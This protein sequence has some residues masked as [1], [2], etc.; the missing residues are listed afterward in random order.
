M[1]EKILQKINIL[2]KKANC[3]IFLLGNFASKKNRFCFDLLAK[4]D[5]L[6]F[7]VKIFNNIDNL[8]PGV[9]RDIKSLSLILKSKPIL[10]GIRNRYQKLED[11]TIY[12]REDLPFI[13]LNT[14]ENLINKKYPY[15]LAR[16]GRGVIFLDGSL[17]KTVREEHS[18]T[19]KQLSEQLGVTKRTISAYENESMRPSEMIAEKILEI[20][21]NNEIFK[22]IDV[23]RWPVKENID[24]KE[25]LEEKELNGFEAHV[26]DII[27]DIGISSYWY[28]KGPIPF[29]L[30]IYST[31][32]SLKLKSFYPL[33]S[34]ISEG[35][36]KFDEMSFKCLKVFTN[37]F[38]KTSLF[39][40]NNNIQI[41]EIFKNDNIPIVKIKKLEKIDDEEEFIEL[42]QES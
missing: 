36:N 28:K 16:R 4:K 37:L 20:L 2:L 35:Q 38:H 21:E 41:P 24:D 33:F 27:R 11:N 30:S 18:I 32:D 12:I 39:I 25:V 19:R 29:K 7:S 1:I 17:M 15:I 5:E 6:V 13:T 26:Q 22:R 40:I 8:N 23:F 31:S 42:I 34:G 9:I 3:E 14:F 10:I